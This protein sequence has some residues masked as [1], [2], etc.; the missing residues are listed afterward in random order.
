MGCVS[1]KLVKKELK[2]KQKQ[3]QKLTF[4]NGG[5]NHVVS[6]TS[7]TYGALNLDNYQKPIPIDTTTTITTIEESK[8]SVFLQKSSPVHEDPEIINAWELME[9]IEEGVPISIQ[10]KKSPK[11][12]PF[13]RGFINTPE[14]KSSPLKFF[15]QNGSPKSMRKSSGKE[16]K[17]NNKVEVNGCKGMRRLDYSYSPKGVLKVSNSCPSTCK[18]VLNLNPLKVSPR[19]SFGSGSLRKMRNSSLFDADL[20]ASNEKEM[21]VGEEEQIKKMVYATPKATRRVR[22]SIDSE[23]FL[24]KFEMKCPKGGENCVVIYTTTLRGIRK[25][26]EDCNKVRAIVESCN[27]HMVERDVSMHSGFKEELRK[28][29]GTKEVKVPVVFVKGRFIGG[30]DETL[31]LEEEE[32]LGVLL[33]GIPKALGCCEG[34]C[35]VRFVICMEC[36][37][38]CKVLDEENKNV[39]CARCNENGIIQCPTC[40]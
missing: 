21:H 22:K 1:S 5:F 27:V 26:F 29:M 9:G 6:L 18:S 15:N 17:N 4:N 39:R 11:L 10:L 35:G 34:C 12:N 8:S 14:S 30:V 23:T 31:K 2:Q 33:E 28:L 32:K 25:T 24:Q 40:S 37:G 19:N 20:V 16:N 36:N 13:L 3:K 38:S 7:S